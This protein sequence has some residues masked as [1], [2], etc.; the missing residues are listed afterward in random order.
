MVHI[1]M[2]KIHLVAKI[3]NKNLNKMILKFPTQCCALCQICCGNKDSAEDLQQ[4]V[5]NLKYEATKRNYVGTK[6]DFGG[7]RAAFVITTPDEGKLSLNLASIGFKP[8]FQFERRVGYPEGILT[9]WM[10]NL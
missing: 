9:M 7:Q 1:S 2:K 6:N 8:T 3:N 10:I 5:N 4:M